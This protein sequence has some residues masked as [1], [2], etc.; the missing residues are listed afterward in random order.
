MNNL[1]LFALAFVFGWFGASLTRSVSHH[2]GASS[3][4]VGGLTVNSNGASDVL[5]VTADRGTGSELWTLGIG[6][7]TLSLSGST[8]KFV[9]DD[10]FVFP[11]P[12]VKGTAYKREIIYTGG[13]LVYKINGVTHSRPAAKPNLAPVGAKS[14]VEGAPARFSVSVSNFGHTKNV[15]ATYH[16]YDGT[17]DTTKRISTGAPT[18]AMT[19]TQKGAGY[20]A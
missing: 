9:T 11:T 17:P 12:A 10:G 13:N 16:L 7:V 3:Y 15:G 2:A 1:I 5:T 8:G 14:G 4:N 18:I 20:T 19:T 6:A